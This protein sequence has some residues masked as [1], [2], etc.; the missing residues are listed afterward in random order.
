MRQAG[1]LDCEQFVIGEERETY[2]SYWVE[3]TSEVGLLLIDSQRIGNIDLFGPSALRAGITSVV[4]MSA[5]V[6]SLSQ[7]FNFPGEPEGTDSGWHME[8]AVRREM[9]SIHR[10]RD[11]PPM[12]SSNSAGELWDLTHGMRRLALAEFARDSQRILDLTDKLTTAHRHIDIIDDQL[13]SHVRPTS[14]EGRD[15]RVVPLPPGGGARMMQRGSGP[16]IRRGG[17]GDDSE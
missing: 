10:L 15:V 16:Q 7:D 5:S 6:H 8:W 3:Q 17:T 12:S 1:F 4:V 14:E 13:Y 2:A 11:P 9:L